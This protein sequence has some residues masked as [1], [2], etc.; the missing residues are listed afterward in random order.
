MDPAP[1]STRR[2]AA[3]PAPLLAE[4]RRA[5]AAGAALAAVA[6]AALVWVLLPGGKPAPSAPAEEPRPVQP[7]AAFVELEKFSAASRDADAILARC[8]RVRPLVRNTPWAHRVSGIEARARE[9]KEL[10]AKPPPPVLTKSPDDSVSTPSPAPVEP[11]LLASWT[12]TV[13][14]PALRLKGEGDARYLGNW[15]GTGELAE[16]SVEIP[17]AGHWRVEITAA[18][19]DTGG[20]EALFIA[21]DRRLAWTVATTGSFREYRTSVLG[22]AEFPAGR[23]ACSLRASSVKGPGLLNLRSLRL[24]PE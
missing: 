12:A 1:R 18:M 7:P 6:L 15:H 13:S 22:T 5:L 16:W 11:I 8:E 14:G 3:A 2:A 21:G 20:G 4:S 17:R 10:T 19:T 9:I 24:V 23:L